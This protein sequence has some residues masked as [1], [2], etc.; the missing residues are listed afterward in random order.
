MTMPR[1]LLITG[2]GGFIGSNGVEV[3]VRD[4][5]SGHQRY[6]QLST[7]EVYGDA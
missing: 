7:D 5:L 1:R 3:I 6:I 2:G 4:N